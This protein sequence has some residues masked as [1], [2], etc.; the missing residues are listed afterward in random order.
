[1]HYQPRT[2][3]RQKLLLILFGLS[4]GFLILEGGLR[5]AGFIYTYLQ[6]KDNLRSLRNNSD[7]V[8]LCLGEST[9]VVG[10]KESYPRQLEEILNDR[11]AGISFSVI[12]RGIPGTTT[13]GILSRLKM[14]LDRYQ[15]DMVISM[16]GIND[17]LMPIPS[18]EL[19]QTTTRSSAPY[20]RLRVV[21]LGGWLWENALWMMGTNRPKDSHNNIPGNTMLSTGE[22]DEGE[23]PRS[24]GIPGLSGGDFQKNDP[25]DEHLKR[26]EWDEAIPLL[27]K[28]LEDEPDNIKV[29]VLLGTCYRKVGRLSE[30]ENILQRALALEPGNWKAHY[31]MGGIFRTRNKP[32]K[33]ISEYIKAVKINPSEKVMNQLIR[34][35]L[36]RSEIL[37]EFNRSPHKKY[38]LLAVSFRYAGDNEAAQKWYTRA[39]PE[40]TPIIDSS[41]GEEET[42]FWELIIEMAEEPRET[43]MEGG[44]D[45]DKNYLFWGEAFE[46]CGVKDIAEELYKKSVEVNPCSYAFV[47][48]GGRYIEKG[49]YEKTEKLCRKVISIDPDNDL[50]WRVLAFGC[51]KQGRVKEAGEYREKADKIKARNVNQT[52]ARYYQE[53]KDVVLSRGIQLVCVQ[54]PMRK[55]DHL[56]AILPDHRGIEFVDNEEIFKDAVQKNGYDRYFSDIFAGDF[57]HCTREGNRLLAS[58]IAGIILE[59]SLRLKQESAL[60]R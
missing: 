38:L 30:S 15:P 4:I 32:N 9:T 23:K 42:G 36:S 28:K 8:I 14:N 1:M 60:P 50:A 16:M 31:E 54:Y 34:A 35:Y 51:R 19:I 29:M 45:I 11:N 59:M 41:S 3:F 20:Q 49:N 5:L 21:K 39:I 47:W 6:E 10:G 27:L 44:R 40:N 58:N 18:G 7:Y 22:G 57:G 24:G 52:V 2:S 37:P 48:L 56:K 12:N 33:S 55:L 53:M 17:E 13:R 25:T 26:K 43:A 46:M